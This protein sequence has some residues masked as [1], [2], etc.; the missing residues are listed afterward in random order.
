MKIRRLHRRFDHFFVRR[1]HQILKRAE[2]DVDVKIIQFLIK[3]CQHCQ[4]F[5]K[6]SKRFNFILKNDDV[7][8]NFNVTVNIFYI[9][10][11]SMLH[12]VNE[13]TRFQTNRWLKNVSFKHVWNQLRNCW[14]DIYFGFFDFISADAG[15]QFIF[16]KFKQYVTNMRIIVK[17]VFVKI[18]HSID[19]IEKH[20]GFFRRVYLIIAA[21]IFDIDSNLK[22]QMTFKTIN[23]SIDFHDLIFTLLIFGTYFRM[24]ELNVFFLTLFNVLSPWRR[25]WMKSENSMLHDKLM[26]HWIRGTDHLQFICT[27]FFQCIRFG[28]SRTFGLAEFIQTPKFEK[29]INNVK[30]IERFHQIQDHFS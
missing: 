18:H 1:L 22:L 5:E 12:F 30:I 24:T 9:Q 28:V 25:R 26:M 14:I 11:K 20:H 15:R 27:I 29:R 8:F 13:A 17:N 2:H 4:K 7:D 23:D 10:N 21:E 19:Q 3:Y 6:F 16:Q